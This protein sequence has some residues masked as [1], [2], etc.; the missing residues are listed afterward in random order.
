M[1][2]RLSD[3]INNGSPRN[4]EHNQTTAA[5]SWVITHNL[6]QRLNQITCTDTSYDTI[7]PDSVVF[8]STSQVTLTFANNQDG[9]AVISK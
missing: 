7:T 1:A 9:Y 4:Y 8:N 5:S 3:Y 6:G 2:I